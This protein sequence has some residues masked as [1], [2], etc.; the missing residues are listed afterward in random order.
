[1][2]FGDPNLVSSAGLV[3]VVALAESAG[4]GDL[5]HSHLTVPSDK[6]ANPG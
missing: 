3:P 2:V 6:G 4:L 1:V 5:A